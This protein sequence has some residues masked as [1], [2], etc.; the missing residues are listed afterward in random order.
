[1]EKFVE[2]NKLI[3]PENEIDNIYSWVK[4]TKTQEALL[5][6][7]A[8][9]KLIKHSFDTDVERVIKVLK[10][11]LPSVSKD[12]Y[13]LS[14]FVT[15]TANKHRIFNDKTCFAYMTNLKLLNSL[16]CYLAH[17]MNKYSPEEDSL[18]SLIIN[19]IDEP[20]K[21]T[22]LMDSEFVILKVY[23]PL[24]EHKYRNA[25]LDML[26]SRRSKPYLSTLVFTQSTGFLIDKTLITKERAEDK[27]FVDLTPLS[28]PFEQRRKASYQ[29][30]M[31]TWYEMMGPDIS[32]FVY[33]KEKPKDT[34]RQAVK[35]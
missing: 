34:T 24:P 15:F 30:I 12:S 11:K 32:N 4:I 35:Y 8:Y 27:K 14:D 6:S 9:Y 23:A 16:A 19:K 2:G 25:I 10:E 1:M 22:K 29:S 20:D 33:S 26:L 18:A 7:E 31:K 17:T 3:I 28:A 13:T 5:S 21:F